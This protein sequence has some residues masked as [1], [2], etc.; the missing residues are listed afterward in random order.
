MSLFGQK[1]K[2]KGF[3]SYIKALFLSNKNIDLEFQEK[4]KR[5]LYEADLGPSIEKK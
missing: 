3:F 4:L 2:E 1:N 5:I